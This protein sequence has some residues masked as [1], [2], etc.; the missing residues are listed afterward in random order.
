MTMGFHTTERVLEW[1]LPP[2]AKAVLLVLAHRTNDRS[3][4]CDPSVAGLMTATGLKERAVR[5]ALKELE[6]LGAVTIARRSGFRSA[7]I[8]PANP[9]TTCTPAPHAPLHQMPEPLHQMPG[10]PAPHAPEH[11]IDHRRDGSA[12]PLADDAESIGPDFPTKGGGHWRMC[13]GQRQTLALAFPHV[14]L[15]G[16]DRRAIAWLVANP[17]RQKT[18]RGMLKFLSSW[19]GRAAPKVNGSQAPDWDAAAKSL[20][21]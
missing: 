3:G 10:T 12:L 1:R 16:E 5:Y 7:F 14:D 13:R 19:Y 18:H 2:A 21:V 20:K 8:I 4:R 11:N 17:A 15:D 6:N 9:C